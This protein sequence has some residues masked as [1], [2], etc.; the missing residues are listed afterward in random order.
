MEKVIY[1]LWCPEG[2]DTESWGAT[3]RDTLPQTL[4]QLGVHSARLNIDDA[5][6]AAAQALRQ[7]RMAVQ[8]GAL[9]QVCIDCANDA[10]RAPIDAAIAACC[11]QHAAYLVTESVPLHNTKHPAHKGQRTLGFAQLAL[12]QRTPR[13]D[14]ET[15][16]HH[17]Q[18]VQTPMAIETQD[19]FEYVQ[20]TIV[21]AL[22]KEAPAIDAIVEE[23]F[24]AAAM[25]DPYAFFNAVGD[26]A[27]FQRN[28]A[29]MMNSVNRFLDLPIDCIPSSQYRLI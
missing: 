29:R 26:E 21:R 10:L 8:P 13:M 20:N 6:V 3:L 28:L 7:Q 14:P 16:R 27:A 19:T 18:T 23:C 24:P 17:W 9:L 12:L 1:L 25:T 5:D 11:Q 22:T 2:L 15:W 4:T